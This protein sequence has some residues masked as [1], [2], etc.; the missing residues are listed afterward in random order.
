MHPQHLNGHFV[1]IKKDSVHKTVYFVVILLSNL[2]MQ[3]RDGRDACIYKDAWVYDL[4]IPAGKYYLANAGFLLCNELLV[5]YRNVHYHLA[6]WGHANVRWVFHSFSRS[7]VLN[8][9][10]PCNKEELFNLHHTSACNIIE[11]IFGVLKH[12]FCILLLAPEYSMDI[13][14]QIPTT[15]CAIHNFICEHDLQEGVLLETRS[16]FDGGDSDSEPPI[17]QL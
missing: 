2:F 3:L 11:H 8:L 6:E 16:F 14:A 13:Q 4:H 9:Y 5:P 17:Q 1:K 15:L 12:Q 10:R 7:I